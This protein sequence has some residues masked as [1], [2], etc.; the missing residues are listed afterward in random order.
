MAKQRTA[1]NRKKTGRQSKAC[2]SDRLIHLAID[3]KRIVGELTA[4]P[5]MGRLRIVTD[6][7][8]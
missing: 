5:E 7:R 1:K 3:M 4:L 2:D 8:Q 6:I